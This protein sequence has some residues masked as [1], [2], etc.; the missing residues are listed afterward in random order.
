MSKRKDAQYLQRGYLL[1]LVNNPAEQ[2]SVCVPI[3]NDINHIRAFLGQLDMLG[4]WWLW[5]RDSGKNGTL[6]A[7][8]WREIADTVR[9]RIDN[10]ELCSMGCLQ[11][12]QNPEN[13]RILQASNDCGET[14]SDVLDNTC[15]DAIPVDY[16]YQ[17]TEDGELERSSDGG[18]TWEPDPT[19]PRQTTPALPPLEPTTENLKCQAA[20]NMQGGIHDVV[21]DLATV[22]GATLT[23][24]ALAAAIA[25]LIAIIIGA[26][27][28]AYRLIPVLVRF[29][30]YL[31]GIGSTEF[32]AAFSGDDYVALRCAIYCHLNE[33]GQLTDITGMLGDLSGRIS[34]TGIPMNTFTL[35]AR[36]AG[37]IALNAMGS[38]FRGAVSGTTCSDCGCDGCLLDWQGVDSGNGAPTRS[39]GTDEFG[40]YVRFDSVLF[41][42]GTKRAIISNFGHIR[43]TTPMLAVTFRMA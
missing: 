33:S 7:H 28:Q 18:I 34:P 10:G 35:I 21:I 27:T 2:I 6:A 41:T 22:I 12:R 42:D 3:P 30:T 39:T 25:G 38:T 43:Q 19:D 23:V 29:V 9:E 8:V 4:Y 1:P 37:L 15:C 11:L 5:E 32:A 40:D 17:V 14:W 26:P 13:P 36:G 24:F 20:Y 16:I 31:A